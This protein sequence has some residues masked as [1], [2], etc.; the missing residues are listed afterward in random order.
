L[1]IIPGFLGR[2]PKARQYFP[3]DLA[4]DQNLLPKTGLI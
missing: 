3:E 4:H 1:M 2:A